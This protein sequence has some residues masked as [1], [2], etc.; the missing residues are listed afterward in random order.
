MKDIAKLKIQHT[1]LVETH[2]RVN[3]DY[4]VCSENL[5][6]AN[7]VRQQAEENLEDLRK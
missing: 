4:K 1:S 3:A 7:K 2:D 6:M 5:T